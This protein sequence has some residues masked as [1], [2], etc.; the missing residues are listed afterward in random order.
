MYGATNF[1]IC[2]LITYCFMLLSGSRFWWL[3]LHVLI[4]AFFNSLLLL[5]LDYFAFQ[6]D[7]S[8]WFWYRGLWMEFIRDHFNVEWLFATPYHKGVFNLSLSLKW[9][10]MIELMQGCRACVIQ[11]FLLLVERHGSH[12]LVFVQVMLIFLRLQTPQSLIGVHLVL[13]PAFLLAVCSKFFFPG[14]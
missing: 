2:L 8:N 5:M 12:L 9:V 14:T 3:F 11:V 13:Y 7:L 4:E 6:T 1:I 10:G